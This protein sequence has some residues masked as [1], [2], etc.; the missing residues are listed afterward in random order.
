M[1]NDDTISLLRECNA[2]LKMAV[3][4]FDDVMPT[5]TDDNLRKL[6]RES[7][8][9]HEKLGDEMHV[10]LNEYNHD[11]K[12]PNQMAQVM[13]WIKTNFKL[14][15]NPTNEEVADL[16][17]DGCNMGIKSLSKYLN[18]YSEAEEKVKSLTKKLIG[19]EEKLAVELRAY[20]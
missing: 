13:S 16:M 11:E 18:K 9:T 4:S 7:H 15:T 14:M 1:V 19:L 6:L 3:D 20:L 5:V 10:L 8:D 12:D 2:G 17:T